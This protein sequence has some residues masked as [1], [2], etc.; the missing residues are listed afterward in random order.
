MIID[1][2]DVRLSK[3]SKHHSIQRSP[4][5]ALWSNSAKGFVDEFFDLLAELRPQSVI[6][7]G[8]DFSKLL[9]IVEGADQGV[10]VSVFEEVKDR[11]PN[12]VLLLDVL[13]SPIR[14]L[15]TGLK[16]V[17]RSCLIAGYRVMVFVLDLK[18]E[19]SEDPNE[20][21]EIGRVHLRADV[22]LALDVNSLC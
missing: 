20:V 16:I 18:G 9:L 10:A 6:R 1:G 8:V 15:K 7:D 19:V 13:R 2:K 4:I 12:N 3:L 22:G 21:R 14:W 17:S 5:D 11:P